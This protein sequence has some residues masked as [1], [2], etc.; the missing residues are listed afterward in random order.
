MSINNCVS[1]YQ[2]Q[3]ICHLIKKQE[4]KKVVAKNKNIYE[5]H[6]DDNEFWQGL[7]I[8]LTD[9]LINSS[10]GYNEHYTLE[11][12]GLVQGR[13]YNL[14][15]CDEINKEKFYIN[16]EGDVEGPIDYTPSKG[17][18]V[19]TCVYGSYDCPPVWTLRRYRDYTLAQNP[20]GRLFIKTY[21]AISPTVVKLFGNQQWFHKLFKTPLDKWVKKLNHKGVE[22]T[23]YKD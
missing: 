22:N 9:G 17:C 1:G 19:A 14:E 13:G 23:P 8:Q 4:L 2:R 5:R 21:Y 3:V 10:T 11:S 16:P 7:A 12:R 6:K 20:F 18:Y 15:F